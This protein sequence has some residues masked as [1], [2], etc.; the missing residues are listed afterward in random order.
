MLI[1]I[2]AAT[3]KQYSH[4]A[5]KICCCLPCTLPAAAE[6]N[7]VTVVMLLRLITSLLVHMANNC[8][9]PRQDDYNHYVMFL[10]L[11]AVCRVWLVVGINITTYQ[12]NWL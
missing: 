4:Q 1:T 11:L 2:G 9:Q 7:I 12:S 8:D 6:H 10:L 3:S 5:G